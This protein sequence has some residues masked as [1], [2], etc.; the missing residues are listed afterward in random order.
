MSQADP[1]SRLD[2]L[3]RRRRGVETDHSLAFLKDAFSRQ[4]TRP[5]KQ[6]ESFVDVWR[7]LV[8]A[9]LLE[10]TRLE[11]LSRGVL[12][13]AVD[14]SAHLY[15]LDMLLRQGLERQMI[16]HHKGPAFRRVQLRVDDARQSN[17]G[18]G[19]AIG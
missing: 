13:V 1:V 7:S 3:C 6:L 5:F 10:H 11:G 12:R 4:V 9:A 16:R 2:E 18:G 14:S 17:R 15:E 19:Q 8:P